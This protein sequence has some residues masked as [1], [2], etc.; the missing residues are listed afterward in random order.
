MY[1]CRLPNLP[2]YLEFIFNGQPVWLLFI[3]RSLLGLL[4]ELAIITYLLIGLRSAAP[5]Q[6]P[7]DPRLIVLQQS[8]AAGNISEQEYNLQRNYILNNPQK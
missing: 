7:A 8:F 1:C 6:A 2:H 3:L 5:K 4:P